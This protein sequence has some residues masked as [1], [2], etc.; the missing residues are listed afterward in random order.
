[1]IKSDL[2]EPMYF[3]HDMSINASFGHYY[4]VFPTHWHS[5]ME[6]VAPLS[7]D[8]S[9][10][11]GNET[12]SLTENQF[13][14]I[15]P[16]TL[17]SLTKNST[18]PCLVIQFSNLLLP[19]LHDFVLNRNLLCCQTI[20]DSTDKIPFSSNPL[21]SLIKIKNLFYSDIRFKEMRMY[22]ELLHFFIVIGEHNYQI[23]NTISARKTPQQKVYDKKFDAVTGYIKKHFTEQISLEDLAGF[24][25]FSK[26]HFSRIF[27]EYYQM[28]L[29]EY[30]TSL[31]ISRA[32]ELLENPELSIMDV[33]LQSGFSSLPS[34]NRTFKQINNCTPSQFRKM[35]DH[36]PG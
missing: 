7:N 21:D 33:A 12:C 35:F 4:S 16:R 30:I 14:V 13:A 20:L 2:S 29:P 23:E 36:F 3:E 1:M 19:Q 34:F 15:P 32:T 8:M 10:T 6:I 9:I 18:V 31:R 11:I 28:S 17:H 24:A 27:K 25:G 26:Y 5:F 22:E